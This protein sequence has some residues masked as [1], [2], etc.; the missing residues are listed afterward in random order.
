MDQ[1]KLFSSNS[2]DLSTC[3][4]FLRYSNPRVSERSFN[5]FQDLSIMQVDKL[6]KNCLYTG[7]HKSM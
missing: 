5:L 1:N 6:K 4:S 2:C 7:V 3:V